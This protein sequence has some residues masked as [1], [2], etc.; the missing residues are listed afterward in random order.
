MEE[1]NVPKFYTV[2]ERNKILRLSGL[3]IYELICSSECPFLT[4]RIG[5]R[6]CIPE[7][8]FLKWYNSLAEYVNEESINNEDSVD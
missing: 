4:L 1:Y 7:N 5:K 8:N 6:I 2:E 3:I